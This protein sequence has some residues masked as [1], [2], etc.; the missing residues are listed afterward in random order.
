MDLLLVAATGRGA[1]VDEETGAAVDPGKGQVLRRRGAGDARQRPQAGERLGVESG[2]PNG[3]GVGTAGE[4]DLRREHALG[5]EAGIDALQARQA[6]NHQA[7]GDEKDERERDFR[8]HESRSQA[9][10]R[11]IG[12]RASAGAKAVVMVR[13]AQAHGRR[14]AEDEGA[15]DGNGHRERKCRQV[16]ADALARDRVGHVEAVGSIRQ[17]HEQ[18]DEPPGQQQ[19]A[20][21]AGG[22]EDSALRELELQEPPARRAQ[23]GANQAVAVLARRPRE[24]QARDVGARDEENGC[25]GDEQGQRPAANRARHLLA[26]R[27][28]GEPPASIEK[29]IRGRE[30]GGDRVGL[31][32][33]LGHGA[34]GPEPPEHAH[35]AGAAREAP[36]LERIRAER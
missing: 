21:A 24:H 10:L 14:Q 9:A 32:L 20:G 4:R 22:R 25:H 19:T 35:G 12:R 28:D 15:A 16:D 6:A 7:R 17:P 3:T 11:A 2:L 36:A 31:G 13:L 5:R 30:P 8:D 1:A 33:R 18:V 29:G 27:H 26:E 23:G 34:G